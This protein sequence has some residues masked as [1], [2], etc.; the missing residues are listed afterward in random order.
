MMLDH[1]F[2]ALTNVCSLFMATLNVNVT[3]F[4][5]KIHQNIREFPLSKLTDWAGCMQTIKT[6]Q[7]WPFR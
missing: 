2:H 6:R 5:M 4:C 3:I 1:I 7:I